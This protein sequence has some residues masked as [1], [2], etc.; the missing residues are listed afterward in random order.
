M[1]SAHEQRCGHGF[2]RSR[3]PCPACDAPRAKT[4]APP[5]VDR[6]HLDHEQI[7]R[8]QHVPVSVQRARAMGEARVPTSA[9][10]LALNPTRVLAF[11]AAVH[12]LDVADIVGRDRHQSVNEARQ[13]TMWLVRRCCRLSYPQLGTLFGRDHT[14]VLAGVN[15]IERRRA[16]DTELKLYLDGLLTRALEECRG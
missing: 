4:V 8:R 7:S 11:G 2:L 5:A 16:A 12:F 6:P 13:L 10:A 15:A 9:R 1:M 3:V 14:T